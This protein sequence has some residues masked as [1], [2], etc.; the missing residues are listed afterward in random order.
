MSA[1]DDPLDLDLVAAYARGHLDRAARATFERRL[2][3][4]PDLADALR[5]YVATD[6]GGPV[7]PPRT[8]FSDL[9]LDDASL[10]ARRRPVLVLAAAAAL[11]LAVGAAV[12]LRTHELALPSEDGPVA[13]LAIPAAPT[14]DARPVAPLPPAL[15]DYEP[16]GATGLRFLP[17]LA[18]G[19]A[20]ARATGRRLVVFVFHPT[21]P[22]CVELDKTT[23]R[24]ASVAA[25]AAPFV[26]AR[27]DV[28]HL[29][30]PALVE[31]L[32]VDW[33]YFLVEGPD[34]ARV[35]AFGGPLAADAFAD[36]LGAVPAMP[37]SAGR[38]PLAWAAAHEVARRLA[39]ADAA[40]TPAARAADLARA[41]SLAAGSPLAAEVAARAD[42]DADAARRALDEAA[43]LAAARGPDAALAALDAA[44]VRFTG[45]AWADDLAR[46][47][48]RLAA[49]R[50]FPALEPIR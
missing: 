36:R 38:V 40:A 3:A 44:L 9:R 20:V 49:D 42:A 26:F 14:A 46:V 45:T 21:C 35:G 41:A 8:T 29:E 25:S 39:A 15:A 30:E 19:R 18:A 7:P 34:G 33:P 1:S 32:D 5:A 17:S 23:F 24:D 50:R 43:S 16:T 48:A 4:E 31:G 2:A 37:L 11:L 22:Y 47:R 10:A 13:L 28:T 6:D 27:Q 12:L